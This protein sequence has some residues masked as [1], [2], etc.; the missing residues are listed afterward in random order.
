MFV[1]GKH[2][3]APKTMFEKGGREIIGSTQGRKVL[4]PPPK[5]ETCTCLI[6]ETHF[7]C[8]SRE[9]FLEVECSQ[10]PV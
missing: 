1:Q 10:L 2:W 7:A 4:V 9:H 6:P 3:V 5:V 8:T